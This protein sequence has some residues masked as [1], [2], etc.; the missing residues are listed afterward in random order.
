MAVNRVVRGIEV[1]HDLG[2][3]ITM[4]GDE[5]IR[6]DLVDR[7]R[8]ARLGLVLEAA[9]RRRAGQRPVLPRRRLHRHIVAQLG[10]IVQILIAQ[11]DREHPLAQHVDE[12]MPDLAALAP[13]AEPTRHR[14]RQ[15]QPPVRLA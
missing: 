7:P 11:R 5:G 12:A 3:R 15:T 4:R 8:P 14:R 2:W 6:Q 1:E 13:V 9:Q 10:V